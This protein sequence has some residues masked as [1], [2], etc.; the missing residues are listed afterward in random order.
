ME[1]IDSQFYHQ[2]DNDL[3][4][5]QGFFPKTFRDELSEP[6]SPAKRIKIVYKS[7]KKNKNKEIRN[8]NKIKK[9]SI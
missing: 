5:E 4:L 7:V 3:S 2:F 8:K 9:I 1:D 6:K